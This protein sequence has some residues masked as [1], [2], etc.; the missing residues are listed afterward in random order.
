[1][2]NHAMFLSL[3][4]TP[5]FQYETGKIQGNGYLKISASASKSA[6]EYNY[7]LFAQ[8]KSPSELKVRSICLC[9]TRYFQ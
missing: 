7:G 5:S 8:C 3:Q 4:Q 1:M 9:Q 6:F 2:D